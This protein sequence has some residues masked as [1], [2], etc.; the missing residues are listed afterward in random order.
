MEKLV[1]KSSEIKIEVNDDGEYIVINLA[2]REFPRRFLAL[3]ENVRKHCEEVLPSQE[4][5]EPMSVKE[6]MDAEIEMARSVMTDIDNMFGEGAC[7]KIFGDIVPD[8][9]AFTEFFEA[10]IPILQKHG[11]QRNMEIREKYSAT[12]R[13]GR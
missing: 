13:G 12:R 1:R 10:L 6:L 7:R 11:M 3:F 4:N 2:D 8:V 5:A 9:Y